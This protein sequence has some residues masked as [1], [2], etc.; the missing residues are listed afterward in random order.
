MDDMSLLPPSIQEWSKDIQDSVGTPFWIYTRFILS[1]RARCPLVLPADPLRIPWCP[2]VP[3]LSI[4]NSQISLS[5]S[6]CDAVLLP[7]HRI[8][9]Q[10]FSVTS[11][12]LAQKYNV[13]GSTNDWHIVL[14]WM[15]TIVSLLKVVT[16]HST[17]TTP[18][19]LYLLWKACLTHLILMWMTFC[20]R[21]IKLFCQRVPYAS[22][23]ER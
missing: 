1:R 18:V 2:I 19:V 22:G 21:Y 13:F 5:A 8:L 10:R 17:L 23:S 9:M 4:V 20:C 6:L 3:L 11:S 12:S 7:N 14:N 15:Q 16:L